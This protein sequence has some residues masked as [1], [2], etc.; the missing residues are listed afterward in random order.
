MVT[1]P[2]IAG[3]N[4]PLKI[5]EQLASGIPLV[6]TRVPSHTQIL[7]DNVCFLVDPEPRA[8]A[9]GIVEALNDQNRRNEIVANAKALYEREYGPAIY[10]EKVRR[11]LEVLG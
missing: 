8:F 1:S 7:D 9:E 2:R 3:T 6:A 4:T 11:F 5:Y 10:A